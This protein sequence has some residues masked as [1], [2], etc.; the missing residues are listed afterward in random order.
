MRLKQLQFI[1]EEFT[2]CKTNGTKLHEVK[3]IS[4]VEDGIFQVFTTSSPDGAMKFFTGKKA[5]RAVDGGRNRRSTMCSCSYPTK[6]F[7]LCTL[8][9][10]K[11][12]FHP[13]KSHIFLIRDP[14]AKRVKLVAVPDGKAGETRDWERRYATLAKQNFTNSFPGLLPAP[15]PSAHQ[16]SSPCFSI[17]LKLTTFSVFFNTFTSNPTFSLSLS[18]PSHN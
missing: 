17:W 2:V 9:V 14:N 18:F 16:L 15:F 4:D 6:R 11:S 8:R 7:S 3:L 10:S 5:G 1:C 13:H 12:V